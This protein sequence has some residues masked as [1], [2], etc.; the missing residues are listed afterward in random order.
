MISLSECVAE[1]PLFYKTGLRW[2]RPIEHTPAGQRGS[3]YSGIVSAEVDFGDGLLRSFRCDIGVDGLKLATRE[4]RDAY[5]T[6]VRSAVVSIRRMIDRLY[7]DLSL[8]NQEVYL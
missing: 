1:E 7:E 8:P 5:S 2:V 3:T 6:E 4:M